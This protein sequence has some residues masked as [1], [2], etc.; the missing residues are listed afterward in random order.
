M[1]DKVRFFFFPPRVS[2][3]I[4]TSS[5]HYPGNSKHGSLFKIPIEKATSRVLKQP[6]C[7]HAGLCFD[8][9]PWRQTS[10]APSL[11]HVVF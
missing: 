6:S 1:D 11:K 3:N 4:D 5:I 2:E 8:W 10:G 9:D 7:G